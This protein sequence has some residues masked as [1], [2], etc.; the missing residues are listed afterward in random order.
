VPIISVGNITWGGTGKTPCVQWLARELQMMGQRVAIVA[1]GYGGR[2]STEGA[3][4][5]NGEKI[6][7]TARDAGDEPFL[8]ARSLPGVP[9]VIGVD[10]V[11][12]ARRAMEECGATIVV[13]DDGFQFY[14]LRRILDIV[15]L[16]A[17]RPF[18]NGHLMP[19]GRLREPPESLQRAG[20][21][22]LTRCAMATAEEIEATRASI[23]EFS[24]APVFQSNHLPTGA[25]NEYNGEIKPLK[26]LKNRRVAA[27]SALAHNEQ[28]AN[29]LEKCGAHV[30]AHERR[31]D[32]H[33]WREK[34]VRSFSM[35]AKSL[36]AEL[37]LTTE[38]DAVKIDAA[39][40]EPLPLY[41]LVI[42]LDFGDEAADFTELLKD[43]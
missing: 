24:R 34:E 19:A 41:S 5:S 23:K 10:R 39:W 4:V 11:C 15:L 6:L 40:S 17:R 18:N 14:S 28:F 32:H 20:A 35:K 36:G 38:K 1:R 25:R 21:I 30:V 37:L 29:S 16:D 7:L 9:V 43:L 31:R 13:L 26:T 2:L 33:A 42:Q 12:A 8:H 27:L 22:I 3:I